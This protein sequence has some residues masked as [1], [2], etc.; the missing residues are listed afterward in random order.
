[1]REI[2]LQRERAFENAKVEDFTNRAAN[3]RTADERPFT[4]SDLRLLRRHF[5]LLEVEWFGFFCV[6]SAFGRSPS[7][8]G[9]L[10]GVDRALSRTPARFFFWQI[11]GL[12]VKRG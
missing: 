10:S 9:L 2:D 11:A 3:T 5:E 12:G 1:M 6:L 4:F 7:L 8:R